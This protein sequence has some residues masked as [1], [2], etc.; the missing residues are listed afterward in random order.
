MNLVIGL[1]GGIGSGKSTVS[2]YII[3]KGYKVIDCDKIAHEILFNKEAIKQLTS[4]FGESILIDGVIQ[5][6]LLGDI[7][8]NDKSKL[9]ILNE[10]LHPLI[11][12]EVKSKITSG[13]TVLDCP[14][15]FETN[16]IELVDTTL[17]I[18]TNKD[19]QVERLIKRNNLT[20]E[21]ALNRISLQ[22]SLESKRDKSDHV[23]DNTKGLSE[24]HEKVDEVLIQIMKG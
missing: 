20:R 15:L 24:L 7:V 2:D 12:K 17:L 16:F 23:I 9:K 8:F 6:N 10:I 21:E 13:V 1:T 11:Y 3:S 18:Y 14:L 19:T 4:E 22:M 5:R